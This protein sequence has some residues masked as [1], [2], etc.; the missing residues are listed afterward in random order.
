MIE[1]DTRSKIRNLRAKGMTYSEIC[2]EIGRQIPKGT[3]SY[4]CK[5][6][7][8][9]PEYAAR[10]KNILQVN[11]QVARTKAAVTIAAKQKAR[12]ENI[13]RI[14]INVVASETKNNYEKRCLATLYIAEGSKY[15]SYRG[16]ALGSADPDILRLYMSLLARCYK[17]NSSD[18]RARIQHRSDQN[19]E[20]LIEYWAE[21]LSMPKTAFYLS[22]ADKRTVGKPTMKAE[23]KGVCV[24]SC[25]GADIQLELD[26][27]AR[28]YASKLWGIGAVG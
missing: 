11:A 19:S 3:L 23:Y 21:Q 2:N 22:Y 12:F 14:A 13:K 24:I 7:V 1:H 17:K 26:A 20:L 5:G 15:K 9:P 25:S 8:L 4:I 10:H 16:L 28:L 27:I 6:V 18:F